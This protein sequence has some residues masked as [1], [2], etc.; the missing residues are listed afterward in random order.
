MLSAQSGAV[1]SETPEGISYCNHK[2]S[3]QSWQILLQ[4]ISDETG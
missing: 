4:I 2:G 1:H 3:E